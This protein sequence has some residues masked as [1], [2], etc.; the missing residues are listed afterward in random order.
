MWLSIA[1]AR[2][3]MCLQYNADYPNPDYLNCQ[4]TESPQPKNVSPKQISVVEFFK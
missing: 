1:R 2:V 4:L 3:F